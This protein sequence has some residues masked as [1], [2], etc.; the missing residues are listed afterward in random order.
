LSFGT[1]GAAAGQVIQVVSTT[2]TTATSISASGATDI[3]GLSV[4]I[5]PSASANKI[6]VFVN[7]I[8]LE[9][10]ND[11]TVSGT[12]LTFVTAP[13]SAASIMIRYL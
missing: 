2:L 6:L 5:T 1:V 12:T 13:V 9:P 7:G 10:T 8:C 4:I 3:A 11:Y